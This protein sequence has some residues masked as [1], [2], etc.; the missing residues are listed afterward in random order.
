[1]ATWIGLVPRQSGSGGKVRLGHITHLHRLNAMTE[2][3]TAAGLIA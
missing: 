2:W 1:L 3:R